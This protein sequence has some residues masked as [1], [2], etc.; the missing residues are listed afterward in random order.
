MLEISLRYIPA[1]SDVAFL[2]I[3]QTEV[4]QY[5]YYLPVFY[6]H[7]YSAIF[8]LLAGA[9]QFSTALRQRLPRLHRGL[10]YVYILGLLLLA[11]PSGLVMGLHANGGPIAQASFSILSILWFGFTWIAL[12][13]VIAGDYQRHRDFMMRSFALTLSAITLRAWKLLLVQLFHP[14]PMD[15]YVVVSVLGWVPN[16]LLAEYIIFYRVKKS[17]PPKTLSI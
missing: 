16:L 4:T 13:S 11:A 3:K 2:M 1:R 14:A 5:P 17:T 12:R 7:V 10:G 15:V 8:V 6:A 9:F